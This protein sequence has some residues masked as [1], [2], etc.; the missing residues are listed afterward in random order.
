MKSK[1]WLVLLAAL[2]LGACGGAL[3]TATPE[4]VG[5]RWRECPIPHAEFNWQEA[6]ACFGHPMPLWGDRSHYGQRVGLDDWQLTI[7]RDV[8]WTRNSDGLLPL[9]RYTL[10]RNRRAVKSLWGEFGG[11]SPNLS[12]QEIGGQAAWEFAD[13]RRATVIYAGRDVRRLYGLDKA[14]RPYGLAGKLILIGQRDDHYFVVYDGKKIG[15][16]FDS[17]VIAYCCETMLYS[18]HAGQGRYL[19]S[20]VRDGQHYLVEI[21]RIQP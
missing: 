20:G 13:D 10:Y 3:P 6:E 21:E 1:R 15:P 5:L 14:Y 9:T 16:D 2:L 4:D 11:H 17:V 18:V 7:G 19:F 8:Y 12:L